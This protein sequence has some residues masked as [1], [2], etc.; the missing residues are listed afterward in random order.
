MVSFAV[1]FSALTLLVGRQERHLVCKKLSGGLN[2]VVPEKGPLN[3]RVCV[4]ACVLSF[5]ETKVSNFSL[6]PNQYAKRF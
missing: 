5:A 4:R 1:A 6:R 3:V 2:R